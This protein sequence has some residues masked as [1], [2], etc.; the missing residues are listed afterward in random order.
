MKGNKGWDWFSNV[1]FI[2][3]H[4]VVV[5]VEQL[6]DRCSAVPFCWVRRPFDE[7]RCTLTPR[8]PELVRLLG[9]LRNLPGT[10]R[11]FSCI[12]INPANESRTHL[13]AGEGRQ[14]G[15]VFDT[16]IGT[17]SGWSAYAGPV[18]IFL[19]HGWRH[20]CS[21]FLFAL[22]VTLKS[23]CSVQFTTH[24]QFLFLCRREMPMIYLFFV[25][26]LQHSADNFP[27]TRSA[28]QMI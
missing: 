12:A 2:V 15:T 7:S 24:T 3:I 27:V 20:R 26:L 25:S 13:Q 1:I 8:I 17:S 9:R 23:P 18:R 6:Q 22:C 19:G 21:F 16:D 10:S 11:R 14:V 28:I 5:R 4:S